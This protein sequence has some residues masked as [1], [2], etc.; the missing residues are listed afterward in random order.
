MKWRY[1]IVIVAS[2]LVLFGCAPQEVKPPQAGEEAKRVIEVEVSDQVLL[3][4]CQ[5]FWSGEK[6]AEI[7]QDDLKARFKEKYS[8]DA[9]EFEFSFEPADHS[10]VTKCRIYGAI[11][12]SGNR[13]TA[14]LLW[15]LRPYRLDFID[16]DFKK[17]KTGFSWQGTINDIPMSIN[18]SC[19]PQDCIYEAWQHPVGHC[20]GHIWWPASS[21]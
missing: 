15:L 8:V 6:F 14:D 12:R 3:Y 4:Q 11:T 20:H 19:P 2:L 13:Y 9:T 17:S 1:L 5:S 21:Q 16:D 7:S 18:V 10:T